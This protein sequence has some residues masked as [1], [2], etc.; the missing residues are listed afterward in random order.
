LVGNL[1]W[2]PT[3]ED[4]ERLYLVEQLS[5]AKIARI[6]ELKYK[7]PK[8]AESVI[9][10]QL[11]KNGIP[12]RDPAEHTRKAT[13]EMVDVWAMQYTDGQSLKQIAGE[14]VS[15]VTVWLH[16][17]RRGV[18]LRDKIEAQIRAVSRHERRAFVGDEL[19]KA[20]LL[21]L[22][23]GDLHVVRHGR[24]IRVRVSTT[25][26]AMA[27]L[28]ESVFSG[29]SH[30]A[31]YPRRAKLTGFEW[32]LECDLHASFA[33]LLPKVSFATLERT[34]V[35][36]KLAFLAGLFDAEGSVYLHRKRDWCNPELSFTNT[37]SALL[38]WVSKCLD[39]LGYYGKIEYSNQKV[40]RGGVTGVG[41]VGHLKVWRFE[42]VQGL[43]RRLPI[44]HPERLDKRAIVLSLRYRASKGD[45]ALLFEK[46]TNL[47]S[48]I[49]AERDAFV[50]AA[51]EA[52]EALE[53]KNSYHSSRAASDKG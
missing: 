9:L 10:Y 50:E 43:L 4:L 22:R 34:P 19:E 8:V 41:R 46:W 53:R 16:L 29:Y 17:K 49:K 44:R 24:G 51:R 11:K 37:D 52:V 48:R 36:K 28:F 40:E 13:P 3:K 14:S 35:D 15:P 5:A 45:D 27:D 25:H 39:G 38:E 18:R 1:A 26:P 23:F 6:Y 7:T 2:P 30:V 12:R 20:Y 33:F 42:D 31:R 32:T 47:R 21:G